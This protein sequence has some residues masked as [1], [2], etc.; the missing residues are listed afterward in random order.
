MA[1]F[2][3]AVWRHKITQLDIVEYRLDKKG[4]SR[5]GAGYIIKGRKRLIVIIGSFGD[6]NLLKIQTHARKALQTRS[7]TLNPPIS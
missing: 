7:C 1:F 5:P 6:C 3:K 2:K 4:C